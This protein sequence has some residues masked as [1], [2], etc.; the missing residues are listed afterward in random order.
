[1]LIGYFKQSTIINYHYL[2]KYYIK[3]EKNKQN[4]KVKKITYD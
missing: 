4:F 3:K 2:K 1:M